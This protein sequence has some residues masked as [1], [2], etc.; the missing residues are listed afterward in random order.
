MQVE[1]RTAWLVVKAGLPFTSHQP[2]TKE[3]EQASHRRCQVQ[4]PLHRGGR[5]QRSL[6]RQGDQGSRADQEADG[7]QGEDAGS[8]GVH[9]Q[10]YGRQDHWLTIGA[11]RRR[12][13]G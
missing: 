1:R 8:Q 6:S 4:S 7:D 10:P 2:G 5:G 11:D 3:H 12:R 13:G 9:R